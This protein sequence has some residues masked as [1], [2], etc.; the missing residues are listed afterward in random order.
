MCIEGLLM[1]AERNRKKREEF[2]KIEK[3]RNKNIVFILSDGYL[4]KTD[5][6]GPIKLNVDKNVYHPSKWVVN[7]TYLHFNNGDKGYFVGFANE[8]DFDGV[9]KNFRVLY[10]DAYGKE[11]YAYLCDIAESSEMLKPFK[12]EFKLYHGRCG[13]ED[14]AHKKTVIETV[15]GDTSD[16]IIKINFKG[17][18]ITSYK[19]LS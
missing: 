7:K 11:K 4:E 16:D 19:V 8:K 15:Y 1:Y 18:E 17:Y 10:K 12:V 14:Y 3:N 5:G 6:C 13:Y 9:V 2:E